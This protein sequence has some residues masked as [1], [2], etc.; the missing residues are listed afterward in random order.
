MKADSTTENYGLNL[1][2]S[3]KSSYQITDKVTTNYGWNASST[4][5]HLRGEKTAA[6]KRFDTGFNLDLVETL[7]TAYNPD[8]FTWLQPKLTFQSRYN[9]V[10]NRPI[11]DPARGGRIS[12]S[13]R[14]GVNVN[15]ELK[16][17]IETVY[18]PE[19]TK[20]QTS[21]RGRRGKTSQADKPKAVKEIKNPQLKAFLKALHTGSSKINPIAV[22]YSSNRSASEPAALGQPGLKYRMALTK[23]SGLDADTLIT[24]LA[25]LQQDRSLGLRSGFN[26]VREI[27]IT[28]S[29]NQTWRSSETSSSTTSS[30]SISFLMLGTEDK[31]GIP[32]FNWGLRWSNLEK[33]PILRLMRQ[34]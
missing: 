26:P 18:K 22:T 8:I 10:K 29:H 32:F 20:G 4:L 7:S 5:N 21:R 19:Q 25:A 17:I 1:K 3:V 31:V 27:S 11:E 24:G 14:L 28:F 12:N 16:K 6:L 13:G 23:L 2:R 15:L 33:L 9:W 30:R 34:Y